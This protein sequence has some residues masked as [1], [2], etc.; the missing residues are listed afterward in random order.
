[1]ASEMT[2]RRYGLANMTDTLRRVLV[3]PPAILGAG[4]SSI[5]NTL[6]P[7]DMRDKADERRTVPDGSWA[8]VHVD[9]LVALVADVATGRIAASTDPADGPVEGG[10]T[11]VNVAGGPAKQRDYYEVVTGAVGV[12]PVW[13]DGPAWTGRI[14]SHRARAWGWAPTVDLPTALAEID[15]GLRG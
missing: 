4:D 15:A 5:W 14:L 10:C 9:D 8:W 11:P 12:D 6:R 2:E 3:R 13:E 1:M 7:A